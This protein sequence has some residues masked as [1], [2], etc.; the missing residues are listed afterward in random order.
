MEGVCE[1]E[2]EGAGRENV[3]LDCGVQN[4]TW[5]GGG[6]GVRSVFGMWGEGGYVRSRQFCLVLRVVSW[7]GRRSGMH[8]KS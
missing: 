4:M 6:K 1:G 2:G 8:G 5:I 3:M 7:R